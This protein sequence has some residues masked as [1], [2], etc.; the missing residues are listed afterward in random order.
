MSRQLDTINN[1]VPIRGVA[2]A[3]PPFTGVASLTSYVSDSSVE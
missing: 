3:I 1:R 2:V